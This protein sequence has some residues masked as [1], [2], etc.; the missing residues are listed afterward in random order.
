M[1]QSVNNN[2]QRDE[3]VDISTPSR[4]L[5]TR[6]AVVQQDMRPV[7]YPCHYIPSQRAD[8]REYV[9]KRTQYAKDMVKRQDKMVFTLR[10]M[11]SEMFDLDSEV[12]QL[13]KDAEKRNRE[14]K[15]RALK[16]PDEYVTKY[17]LKYSYDDFW[18]TW[19]LLWQVSIKCA[20]LLTY[21]WRIGVELLCIGLHLPYLSCCSRAYKHAMYI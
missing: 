4:H 5:L 9:Q 6:L 8:T 13:M 21:I 3:M 19:I 1:A 16:N 15:Y 10:H 2:G 7:M 11:K 18:K 14:R 17:S 12:N 20:Y